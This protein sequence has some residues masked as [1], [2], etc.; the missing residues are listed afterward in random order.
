MEEEE[1]KWD[2]LRSKGTAS[3]KRARRRKVEGPDDHDQPL[4]SQRVRV[5]RTH[6]KAPLTSAYVRRRAQREMPLGAN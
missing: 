2:R 1:E 6:V 3:S 5:Y 4:E